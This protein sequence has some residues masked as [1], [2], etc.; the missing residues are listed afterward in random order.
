MDFLDKDPKIV[1]IGD[2]FFEG[3]VDEVQ[4]L[5]FRTI[6]LTDMESCIRQMVICLL[7]ILWMAR[8]MDRQFIF[9]KMGMSIKDSINKTKPI[10]N[11][12]SFILRN[13]LTKEGSKMDTL[14]EKAE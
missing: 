13:S 2:D 1:E 6:N 12:G 11:E 14:M 10:Q 7:A 9:S 8:L 4:Y 3:A 5:L